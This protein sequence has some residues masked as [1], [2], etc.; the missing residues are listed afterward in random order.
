MK[1]L[2]LQLQEQH[3]CYCA[4]FMSLVVAQTYFATIRDVSNAIKGGNYNAT[5]L[6]TLSIQPDALLSIYDGLGQRSEFQ[7]SSIHRD[8][9]A[10]LLQELLSIASGEDADLAQSA[11]YVLQALQQRSQ[12]ADDF[13]NGKIETGRNFLKQ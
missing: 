3:V 12:V 13:I 6:V 1:D 2:S 10:E 8:I 11:G 4:E 7:T 9:K 5:D